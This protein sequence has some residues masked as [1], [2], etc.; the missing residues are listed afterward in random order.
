[1]NLYKSDFEKKLKRLNPRYEIKR[2]IGI[3]GF[4]IH[5]RGEFIVKVGNE[6]DI[7][8]EHSTEDPYT[9]GWQKAYYICLNHSNS[10]LN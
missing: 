10:E 8:S 7:I 2:E 3:P 1:M 9:R 4:Q 6:T 5:L